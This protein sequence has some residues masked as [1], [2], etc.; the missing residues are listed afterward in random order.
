MLFIFALENRDNMDP[1]NIG[2]FER[3]EKVIH[4]KPETREALRKILEDYNKLPDTQSRRRGKYKKILE[5][6][7]LGKYL[8]EKET[9]DELRFIKRQEE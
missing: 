2:R 4:L 5:Y 6:S 1:K 9:D 3:T 7:P 8:D